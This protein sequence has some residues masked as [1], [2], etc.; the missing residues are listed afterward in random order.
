[1]STEQRQE[2]YNHISIFPGHRYTKDEFLEL[3]NQG[4]LRVFPEKPEAEIMREF[5]GIKDELAGKTVLI[6]MDG[7]RRYAEENGIPLAESHKL[8]V[9]RLFEHCQLLFPIGMNIIAWGFS[10]DNWERTEETGQIFDSAIE[11]LSKYS[12]LLQVMSVRFLH[13]GRKDRMPVG[14]VDQI[15]KLENATLKNTG[16]IL[17]LAADFGS[18]GKLDDEAQ[19]ILIRM[20]N[21]VKE[22]RLR[23]KDIVPDL[24]NKF[25]DDGGLLSKVDYVI[26]PGRRL[27]DSGFSRLRIEDANFE[28]SELLMPELTATHVA[29]ILTTMVQEDEEKAGRWDDSFG[30]LF[31]PPDPIKKNNLPFI[32]TI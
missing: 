10:N 18:K 32:L 11:S 28:Y 13:I 6:I 25:M 29:Q 24:V 2:R 27:T 30:D 17:E 15:N 3:Q 31:L 8:G 23:I 14:L 20:L 16:P 26:R 7:H 1:M 21:E 22:G 12:Y 9:K 4:L 5:N 19:R